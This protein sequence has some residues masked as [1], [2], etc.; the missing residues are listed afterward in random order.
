MPTMGKSIWVN[1]IFLCSLLSPAVWGQTEAATLRGSVRDTSQA[2]VAG[3]QVRLTNI[4][5]NRTWSA[6]SNATGAY[7]IEQIPPGRYS[8]TVEASGFKRYQQPGITLQANQIANIDVTLQV[9]AVTETVEVQAE[10][11]LLES[12]SSSLGEVVNHLTT[13]ALP[14]NGRNVMQLVALTPG[15]NTTPS[16]RN[17]TQG[18][19]IPSVGFSANG[20]RNVST[21]V[22]LDGSPQEVMG[23]NQ[24][25]YVPPPDA[26]AE[27]KVMTNSLSAEYGRTGA[28]VV[29]MVH[30]SG[31]KDLHGDVYEFL[32][33]DVL[34]AND[35]F[36]NRS[37]K[38][39]APFR[40]NQF[41]ATAGGPLTTSRESTFFFFSYQGIRQ[42]NPGSAFYTVPTAAMK[43]GDF[44]SSG[45][46]IYDPAT[47]NAQGVREQFPGDQIPVS[48]FNPTAVKLL[49][50]YPDPNRSGLSNNFFSQAGS[51]SATNDYSVR[52][53]RRISDRQNLF[54]R[55]SYM[56]ADTTG[57]DY[58]QNAASPNSGVSGTR[59]RSA[60]LDDTYLLGGWVFHGNYGYGYFANP[61]DSV[62][63]GFDLTTLGFPSSLAAE[64]QFAVFPVI[65]PQGF[66]ALGPNAS[67]IIGN[68]FETHTWTGDVTHLVGS[69]SLKFGGVY[70]LN[71]VSNFRPNSPAGNFSFNRSWT[72][73]TFNGSTGGQPV[74]SMLLG[75]MSSGVLQYQP[76]LALEVPYVAAYLQDDWRVSNRLTLN[77]GLRWDSDRPMSERFNRLSWFNFNAQL[78][79]QVA[80]LPP[81]T[82]GLEF[83]GQDGNPRGS[84]NPDNNNFAPRVGLAFKATD[85][86]V[87]RSGFGIFYNPTT[88]T[89]PGGPSVGALTFDAVTNV[90][91]STDGGRTPYTTLS[92][93]FPN[94]FNEPTHGSEGLLSLLGDSVN[95]QFRNDRAP[96]SAQWNFDLQYQTGNN[97]LLDIAYAGNS[98]V[99]LLAQSQLNQIPDADLALGSALTEKV[100][101]PFFGIVP[102]SANLGKATTTAGQLLRPYPQFTGVQQTWGAMAHSSY[103]ALQI[104]FRKRY[105]NGLQFLVAYT[106]SKLLDDFSS[107]AGFLG[108]QNPG[109][110][111]NN[112]RRL[113]RSLS[114]L[115]VAH[116]L[117]ANYQYEL[118]FGKGRRYLTHGFAGAVLGGWDLNGI[119]TIQSGLPISISSAVNTTNSLGGGQRP[120]STGI[121]TRSSGSVTE[122]IDGYFNPAAFADAPLF[123]FGNIGRTL[124]D[125]RGPFFVNWDISVLRQ[126]PVRENMHVELRGELFNAFNNV[127]FKNPSGTTYGL[128]A[129]GSI[130]GTFQPRIIQ[131]AAKF[132]F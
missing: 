111:D 22:L 17:A 60:T 78:P 13:V 66:A 35:F 20:G 54:G 124:S 122:R 55:F 110:T 75:L 28:A 120:N 67:W 69:H 98:G 87:V 8:V 50:Y 68:K 100:D 39:R 41:G 72:T 125:N 59:S 3:A 107:V 82:G 63:E 103:N 1:S 2:V 32:R 116:H 93:P 104:K 43:Q 21:E 38:T 108:Q 71:R 121:S 106:W 70:R 31:T 9:G 14:L 24:P 25:A 128:P 94:G 4:D 130:T 64:S 129:F 61:R 29:S 99:K 84:K 33:N 18:N 126:I 23:Y 109:Y 83:A 49:S 12:A 58:F 5:Q 113:D 52:I 6:T 10:A 97:M 86:L 117:V 77:L 96:Y 37:G 88:G 76:A 65:Q 91:T 80:G 11:P 15:I 115:D 123:T 40:Y 92:N 89:G 34:D 46:H 36:G 48:R 57:A 112:N 7:D 51:H 74:A 44:S 30:R 114:A 53:D 127:N 131:V 132:V 73:Q 42:S 90:T 101:N 47:I 16:E 45:F 19:S 56:N 85:R 26:I 102:S 79:V 118:P 81:L 62:S 95:A 105:G 119:T 27:F